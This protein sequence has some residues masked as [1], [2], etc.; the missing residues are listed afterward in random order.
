MNKLQCTIDE[1][2]AK[3]AN[4]A[5]GNNLI[6]KIRLS[7]LP[8]AHMPMDRV[9]T[10]PSSHHACAKLYFRVREQERRNLHRRRWEQEPSRIRAQMITNKS[11]MTV[12]PSPLNSHMIY[13]RYKYEHQLKVCPHMDQ[14]FNSKYNAQCTVI[15]LSAVRNRLQTIFESEQKATDVFSF[16]TK[17]SGN[18]GLKIIWQGIPLNFGELIFTPTQHPTLP[19]RAQAMQKIPPEK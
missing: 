15:T 12:W 17:N 3:Q 16:Q 4:Q 13:F 2:K 10:K 9:V 5:K 19:H 7:T 14:F 18:K 1:G 11:K 8:E 6:D